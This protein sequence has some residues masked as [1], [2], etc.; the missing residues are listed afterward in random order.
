MIC[1]GARG[2]LG[3]SVKVAVCA[4]IGLCEGAWLVGFHEERVFAFAADYSY[5]L[6]RCVQARGLL[7]FLVRTALWTLLRSL[8]ASAGEALGG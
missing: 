8:G 4:R 3:G 1:R 7:G 2:L 6:S 5:A